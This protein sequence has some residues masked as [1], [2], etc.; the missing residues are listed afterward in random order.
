MRVARFRGKPRGCLVS[1]RSLVLQVAQSL[2]PL[3]TVARN[4]RVRFAERCLRARRRDGE[5]M[6]PGHPGRRFALQRKIGP[7][8]AS[9]SLFPWTWPDLK[10]GLPGMA[11]FANSKTASQSGPHCWWKQFS[12]VCRSSVSLGPRPRIPCWFSFWRHLCCARA[13]HDGSRGRCKGRY[14][15]KATRHTRNNVL[16]YL[17][18][19][20]ESH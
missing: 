5:T 1:R 12:P 8:T 4:P 17:L 18:V 2:L 20:R 15:S 6:Q 7:P 19:K 3:L 14:I 10:P 9:G 13:S 11:S 16:L